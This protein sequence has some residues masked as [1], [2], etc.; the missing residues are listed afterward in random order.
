MSFQ[1][2]GSPR[3]HLSLLNWNDG[4]NF[5]NKMKTQTGS[6]LDLNFNIYF[7]KLKNNLLR[8][9][10]S[11]SFW[12][13][14]RHISSCGDCVR[15]V[16]RIVNGDQKNV[17]SHFFKI[18]HKSS[19]S[20]NSTCDEKLRYVT[21]CDIFKKMQRHIVF[22]WPLL[23]S[24]ESSHDYFVVMWPEPNLWLYRTYPNRTVPVLYSTVL[25]SN[26]SVSVPNCTVL[27]RT[28][29]VLKT[30]LKI[31]LSFSKKSLKYGRNKIV[32]WN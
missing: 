12:V 2:L 8:T 11:W 24:V 17:T 9:N 22:C 13:I 14:W 20:N 27:L 26:Q 3:H 18:C 25:V 32:F 31:V 4:R 15:R 30:D 7:H 1:H 29:N 6:E 28:R 19:L 23:Q 10:I 5:Q 16:W 21:N